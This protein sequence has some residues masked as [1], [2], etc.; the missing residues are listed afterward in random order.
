MS[1]VVRN[2]SSFPIAFSTNTPS[3]S[4][5]IAIFRALKAIRSASVAL[6]YP[7]RNRTRAGAI[8]PSASS[9]SSRVGRASRAVAVAIVAH[10]LSRDRI[11]PKPSRSSKVGKGIRNEWHEEFS[12]PNS[13]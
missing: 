2:E 12:N 8:P 9:R 10:L 13:R 7:G 11:T 6:P 4:S 5:Q 1:T 3:T